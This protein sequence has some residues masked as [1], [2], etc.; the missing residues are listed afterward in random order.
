[1][2][3]RS[4]KAQIIAH[5]IQGLARTVY[6]LPTSVLH[7]AVVT[8]VLLFILYGTEAWYAGRRKPSRAHTSGFVSARVRWHAKQ[9]NKTIAQASRE[10]LPVWRTTPTTTLFRDA[11]RPSGAAALEEAK[12][13]FAVRLQTID[14]EHLLV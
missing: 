4:A 11:G 13:R 2:F 3:E 12:L 14:N 9:V 5:H 7:K 6:S 8:C 10:V 1:M